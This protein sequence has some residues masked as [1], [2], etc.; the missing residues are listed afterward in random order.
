MKLRINADDFG[1][2]PGVNSAIEKMFQAGRLNSASIIC[3][4]GY[5]DE[6]IAI[7]KRNPG[8]EI[9]LHFNATV[10]LSK[11]KSGFLR[12]FLM[13]LF[14]KKILQEE[15]ERELRAQIFLLEKNQI[16]I[17]HIDSHRHIHMIPRI[18]SVVEKVAKEKGINRIR[19][20]NESLLTTLSINHPKSYF[21]NGNIIKWSILIFFK[22]LNNR[23][24]KRYFFSILY[25]C[26]VTKDLIKKI[27][28]PKKFRDAEIEIMIHP[29]DPEMDSKIV[30]L[31]EKAHLVSSARA[32]ES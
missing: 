19:I 1:I 26:E 10:G 29:G 15:I 28:V 14:N 24:E 4:C 18:F 12:L 7:A 22:L 27:K 5:F 8:L 11:F 30:G 13:S 21:W 16:K 31:E 6:A 17:S 2:S 25:T 9:G 32:R 3:G 20:I 23:P